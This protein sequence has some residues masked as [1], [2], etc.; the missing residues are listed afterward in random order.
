MPR[1]ARRTSRSTCTRCSRSRRCDRPRRKRD[2]A[3]VRAAGRTARAGRAPTCPLLAD[4]LYKAVVQT[5]VSGYVGCTTPKERVAIR[6]VLGVKV[7]TEDFDSFAGARG[8]AAAGR[9][10]GRAADACAAPGRVAGDD[11]GPARLFAV[12]GEAAPAA[13][14]SGRRNGAGSSRRT[15]CRPWRTCSRRS[16]RSS[17]ATG[18]AAASADADS[19]SLAP[20]LARF[21]RVHRRL[22]SSKPVLTTAPEANTPGAREICLVSHAGGWLTRQTPTGRGA[23]G[24]QAERH[25]EGDDG[26]GGRGLGSALG[27]DGDRHRGRVEGR[28]RQREQSSSSRP[29]V[30]VPAGCGSS[31]PWIVQAS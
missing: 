20:R 1:L 24:G 5:D 7:E 2:L 25:G 11:R 19:P 13:G 31:A 27:L 17:K 30:N 12:N 29:G 4:C 23:E 9:P 3:G 6:K 16:T 26:V 22:S 8:G 15:R 28:V 10:R 14:A 18:L 21:L